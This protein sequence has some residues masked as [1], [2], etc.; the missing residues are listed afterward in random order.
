MPKKIIGAALAWLLIAGVALLTFWPS[1]PTSWLGWLLLVIIG[2]PLYL[3]AETVGEW[4]WASGPGRKL[5]EHPSAVFRMAVGVVLG[6]VYLL[7][8]FVV[9]HWLHGDAV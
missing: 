3:L 4:A 1:I 2:P 7:V 8:I 9:G 5:S 6:L